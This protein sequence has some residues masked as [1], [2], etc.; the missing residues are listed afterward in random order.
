MFPQRRST[1]EVHPDG[2]RVRYG[3]WV[4]ARCWVITCMKSWAHQKHKVKETQISTSPPRQRQQPSKIINETMSSRK[5]SNKLTDAQEKKISSDITRTTSG[6]I[7]DAH[8][9][10]IWSLRRKGKKGKPWSES[11]P[12]KKKGMVVRG[13]RR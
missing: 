4:V 12:R 7:T 11:N 5:E 8:Q 3:G 6:A 13:P 1:E 10:L 9:D 2:S